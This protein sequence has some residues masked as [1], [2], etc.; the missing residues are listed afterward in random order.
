[1]SA[2]TVRGE[3]RFG[4]RSTARHDATTCCADCANG[5]SAECNACE[6]LHCV[7]LDCDCGD[8]VVA[9]H[10]RTLRTL[11]ANVAGS[12]SR[13]RAAF[14]PHGTRVALRQAGHRA[15]GQSTALTEATCS[16]EMA[17]AAGPDSRPR[18]GTNNQEDQ[19]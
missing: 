19:R 14:V 4:H 17:G 9:A 18:P 11:W 8:E 12:A 16:K 6:R 2:T 7:L 3:V 13:I 10:R 5:W 15:W 1:M